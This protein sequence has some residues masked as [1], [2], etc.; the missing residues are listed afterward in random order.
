MWHGLRDALTV[1]MKYSVSHWQRCGD[2]LWEAALEAEDAGN[3]VRGNRHA[4]HREMFP[5]FASTRPYPESG[6]A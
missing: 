2:G 4:E 1:F 3:P 5:V 6:K